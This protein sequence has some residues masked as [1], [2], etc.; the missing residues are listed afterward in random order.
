LFVFTSACEV[1]A[2]IAGVWLGESITFDPNAATGCGRD[3]NLYRLTLEQSGSEVGGE[4]YWKI[5]ESF[6]PPDVG[7]E[8][9]ADLTSGHVSGSTF[10][11]SYG[12][13]EL[14]LIASATFTGTAMTGTITFE[15]SSSC[16]P[17]T[18]QLIRQ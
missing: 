8:Q 14:G 17:N 13:S 18:F 6:F 1:V 10:T 3:R 2:N 16:E 4:V 7:M 5:L 9:T 12:P 11:F 15:G